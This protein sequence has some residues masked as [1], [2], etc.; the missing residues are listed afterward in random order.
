MGRKEKEIHDEE[1]IKN[2][3]RCSEVCRLGFAIENAPYVVPVSFGFDGEAIFFHSGSTGKK[4]DCILKNNAVCFE[5]EREVKVVPD[6]KSPCKWSFSFESVIGYGRIHEL[7]ED[8]AKVDALNHIMKQYSGRTWTF[9]EK[10]LIKTRAW[11][12]EIDRL[13]G[14]KST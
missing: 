9:N 12:I 3:I 6:E 7:L 13:T 11:K 10:T 2:I 14:K 4:I 8:S 1:K 5:F